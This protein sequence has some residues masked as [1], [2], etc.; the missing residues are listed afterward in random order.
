[1]DYLNR[2][3]LKA[4]TASKELA[5]L[6]GMQK[7]ELLLLAAEAL[8]SNAESILSENE[9]DYKNAVNAD[10][11]G[12]FLDR[13]KL[14]GAR[15]EAMAEGL[16]ALV[17]LK[18]PLGEVE[19]LR[20]LDNGLIIGQKRVPLG[21]VAII[22][23]AR[24]NVTSDAFGICFKTGNSVILRGGKEAFRSNLAIV[25]VFR[26]VLKNC[27]YDENMIQMVEDTSRET[28]VELMKLNSYVDVLIP[29]G[30]M[31]LIKTV[32]QNSTIPV[33]ETAI[34]NCHIFVDESASFDMARDIIVNAKV[35]RPGV[36]NSVEKLL[37]HKDISKEFLPYI[38]DVLKEENV[39]LRGDFVS[40]SLYPDILAATEEDWYTEYADYIIAIKIVSDINEAIEHISTYSSGHSEAIITNN[41]AHSQQFLNEVDS[42]AVYVNASTRFTDGGQFGLG[43]EI[44]IS[45]QKLH[46]RGPMGLKE[47]TSSKYIIFGNG[48]IRQ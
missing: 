44:G 18:D 40:K 6:T 21:V 14:T 24:P 42:A 13:L 1:M 2:I 25:S 35:Q 46:A 4:K 19:N 29:R 37:I 27:G 7:N 22:Y 11:K 17:T 10:V 48:Q 47:M 31:E 12:A 26:S 39:E 41:Y 33:I 36:C 38:C 23:E 32:T 15:I 45:T 30:S 5:L 16:Q 9:I 43:S 3:G 8:V 34:G 28:A 20:T